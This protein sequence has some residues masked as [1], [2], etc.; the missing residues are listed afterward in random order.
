[1]IDYEAL[2]KELPKLKAALTRAKKSK[3]PQRVIAAV[4]AAFK[5]F[6]D[7]GWPDCWHLWNIA[8]SDAEFQALLSR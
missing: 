4:D 6:D 7:I 2:K 3:D 1:M 5:R 8:R